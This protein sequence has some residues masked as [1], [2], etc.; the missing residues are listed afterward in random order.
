MKASEK[1][2]E[3]LR[4]V[5]AKLN[6]VHICADGAGTILTWPQAQYFGMTDEDWRKGEVVGDGHYRLF[7]HLGGR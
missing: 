3:G 7:Q 1:I 6:A 2:Q 5:L 4:E